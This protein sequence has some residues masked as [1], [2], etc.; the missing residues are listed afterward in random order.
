M[1]AVRTEDAVTLYVDLPG[2]DPASIDLSVDRRVLSLTAER[3][4]SPA[5]GESVVARER[6]HGTIRR[7]LRL[8][9]ALDPSG[10]EARYD[11]GV[12]VVRV[13]VAESA[14]PRRVEIATPTPATELEPSDTTPSV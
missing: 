5:D 6:L 10:V 2:V 7:Q 11:N 3:Q 13:P 12:L 1:D 9:D 8:S 4:W 14:Q